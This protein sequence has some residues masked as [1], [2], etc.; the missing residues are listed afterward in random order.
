VEKDPL[1]S[2]SSER[3][4]PGQDARAD[5]EPSGHHFPGVYLQCESG[6]LTDNG[7]QDPLEIV[8]VSTED[9]GPAQE[10]GRS[11]EGFNPEA[12]SLEDFV[13]SPPG[14]EDTQYLDDDDEVLLLDLNSR[15]PWEDQG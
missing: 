5:L 12:N 10:N 13:N 4:W 8:K 2:L 15:L 3:A 6:N 14:G 1:Y 11:G 7:G 9:L